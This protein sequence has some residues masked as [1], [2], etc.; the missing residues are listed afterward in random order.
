MAVVNNTKKL[1]IKF[2][3]MSGKL[4]DPAVNEC[5]LGL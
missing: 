2:K 5:P 3:Q 1:Y 4:V